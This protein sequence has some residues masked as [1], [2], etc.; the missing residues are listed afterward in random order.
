M[1]TIASTHLE[2][3]EGYV[4]SL[5]GRVVEMHALYYSQLVGF[6]ATFESKVASGLADFVPRLGHPGNAIWHLDQGN[7]ILGGLAID[8]EDLGEGTAHL[9]WFII[10][11]AVRGGGFG[12][13]LIESALTFCDGYGYKAIHL[14]TFKGLDAA[15]RLYE[16]NGF[17]LTSEEP[18]NQWGEEVIEQTFQRS[19]P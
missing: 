18:G 14:S 4:P 19:R 15:R 11:D 10:D 16:R 17:V 7:D 13:A 9:R 12:Q 8:G 6:G 5:I 2:I 1:T 3:K